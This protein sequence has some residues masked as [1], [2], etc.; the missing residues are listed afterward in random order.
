MNNAK[1]FIAGRLPEVQVD[2]IRRRFSAIEIRDENMFAVELHQYVLESVA[3]LASGLPDDVLSDAEASSSL[4]RMIVELPSAMRAAA[5]RR[6]LSRKAEALFTAQPWR[7]GATDLQR[8]R[9]ILMEAFDAP[10]NMS[11]TNFAKLAGKVRQQIYEEIKARR[12][13]TISVGPKK[14]KV[15]DWQLDQ[16]KLALTRSVLAAAPDADT[17]TLY[18]AL[19]EPLESLGGRAPVEVVEA[20][21]VDKLAKTVMNLL[22]FIPADAS[23]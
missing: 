6:D 16:T 17:W 8:G 3:M 15:P 12:L 4:G 21:S 7:P 2:D 10:S 5:L 18:K 22:G 9:A 1:A 11:V 23:R 14:Q 20:G 13:L 19:S